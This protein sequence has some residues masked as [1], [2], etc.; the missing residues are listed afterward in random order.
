MRR[1]AAEL[2]V[3][4]IRSIEHSIGNIH[5]HLRCVR[6]LLLMLL[7]CL[8]RSRRTIL[9]LKTNYVVCELLLLLCISILMLVLLLRGCLSYIRKLEV[10]ICD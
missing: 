8:K 9:H 4:A 2:W 10:A 3:R 1:H 6:L 5:L 7:L